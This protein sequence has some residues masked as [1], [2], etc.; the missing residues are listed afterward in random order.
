[1]SQ[2]TPVETRDLFS[3]LMSRTPSRV[4]SEQAKSE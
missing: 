1:M 2:L 3:Y 4:L